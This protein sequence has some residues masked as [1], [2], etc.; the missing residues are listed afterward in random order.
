MQDAELAIDLGA[1][2]VGF[3][4]EPNSP[5]CLQD[6]DV[7]WLR[8]LPPV[9][10]KVA[11]FGRV[12]RHAFKGLYDVVQGV[13]WAEY[14]SAS[15]KRIH[16]FRLR[17]GQK[18]EDFINLTISASAILLDAYREEAYGGTGHKVDWNLAAE[19]VQRSERPVILAGG[20]NP[21]N[22]ADAVRRVRPFMVDVSSG[23]EEKPRFKDPIKLRDFIQAAKEA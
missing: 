10:V 20:L 18:A 22:V 11:V 13:E 6:H 14:P 19:I 3:V 15:P 2:A 8:R 7:E 1:D 4:Q 16:V 9:P 12:D 23:V 21:D 5:R 17:P